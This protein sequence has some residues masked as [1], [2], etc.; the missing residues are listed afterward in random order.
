MLKR[1]RLKLAEIQVQVETARNLF[2]IVK[3]ISNFSIKSKIIKNVFK[4]LHS[5][6]NSPKLVQNPSFMSFRNKIIKKQ[7]KQFSSNIISH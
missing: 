4:I 6:R 3:I 5:G 7:L 2:K 1:N